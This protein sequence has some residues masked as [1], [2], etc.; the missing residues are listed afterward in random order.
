MKLSQN[1]CLDEVSQE[2][3]NGLCRVETRSLSQILENHCVRSR[4][5]IFCPVILKFGKNVCLDEIA[6]AIENGSYEV[7]N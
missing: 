3:E 4:G 5:H 6:D 7:K 1:V 2:F